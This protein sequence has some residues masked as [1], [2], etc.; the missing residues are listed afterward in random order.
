MSN[1]NCES[2]IRPEIPTPNGLADGPT[3]ALK[4][5]AQQIIDAAAKVNVEDCKRNR[6]L[7]YINSALRVEFGIH[8]LEEQIIIGRQMLA[9]KGKRN[10]REIKEYITAATSIY[11]QHLTKMLKLSHINAKNKR[12]PVLPVVFSV[13]ET[14]ELYWTLVQFGSID[15]VVAQVEHGLRDNKSRLIEKFR[16]AEPGALGLV[17]RGILL[18]DAALEQ[19]RPNAEA[20]VHGRCKVIQNM[21]AAEMMGVDQENIVAEAQDDTNDEEAEEIYSLSDSASEGTVQA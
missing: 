20:A 4:I 7:T 1:Q 17:S 6:Y 9:T 10:K 11:N 16:Q 14:S 2:P 3:N 18:I 21:I 13:Q 8:E 15:S 19:W 5:N 12:P